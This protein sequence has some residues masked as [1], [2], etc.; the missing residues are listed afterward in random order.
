MWRRVMKHGWSWEGWRERHGWRGAME[1]GGS[2]GVGG[3]LNA[4]PGSVMSGVE[5]KLRSGYTRKGGGHYP[6][7]SGA[8]TFFFFFCG[9]WF[10]SRGV[11]L[12]SQRKEEKKESKKRTPSRIPRSAFS[13][14][15]F[16]FSFPFLFFPTLVQ[17]EGNLDLHTHE[18]KE[19]K[20]TNPSFLFPLLSLFSFSFFSVFF[21]YGITHGQ[22][23]R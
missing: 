12:S 5:D 23:E 3:S 18:K 22:I 4:C 7:L 20:K 16:F 2:G 11:R 8:L 6:F 21:I 14:P 1:E 10:L 15:P 13:F 17:F 9:G 19:R